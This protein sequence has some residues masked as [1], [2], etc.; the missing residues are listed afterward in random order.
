[1]AIEEALLVCQAEELLPLLGS[2]ML[3]DGFPDR[4]T[5]PFA[6]RRRQWERGRLGAGHRVG[7]W[8]RRAWRG[9]PFRL[10]H[11]RSPSSKVPAATLPAGK[12][13][14]FHRACPHSSLSGFAIIPCSVARVAWNLTFFPEFSQVGREANRVAH[15]GLLAGRV[16]YPCDQEEVR[17]KQTRLSS[18]LARRTHTE[19]SSGSIDALAVRSYQKKSLVPGPWSDQG[20]GTRDQRLWTLTHR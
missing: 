4:A 6:A 18:W 8:S 11:R 16:A 14:G 15:T 10:T 1:M 17:I 20:P 7:G 5:A 12:P 9:L 2:H 3:I 13:P 19:S